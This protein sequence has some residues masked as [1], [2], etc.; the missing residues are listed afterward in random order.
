MVMAHPTRWA[1]GVRVKHR[2]EIAH[3]LRRLHKHA[4]QLP[5]THHAQRG[6]L[7]IGLGVTGVEGFLHGCLRWW[8]ILGESGDFL[9][10]EGAKVSQ[11][12]QKEYKK[13][14]EILKLNTIIY[15]AKNDRLMMT[16]SDFSENF[17]L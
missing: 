16:L 9:N 12:A 4:P 14:N 3:A 5:A 2:R 7:S 11:R 8:V 10:A 13:Y 1:G 17:K 15:I 6:L